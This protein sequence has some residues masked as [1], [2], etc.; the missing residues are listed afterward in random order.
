MS[1]DLKGSMV[2]PPLLMERPGGGALTT[3]AL[4]RTDQDEAWDCPSCRCFPPPPTPAPPCTLTCVP[5]GGADGG[6]RRTPHSPSGS[7]CGPGPPPPAQ[8]GRSP[9]TGRNTR[10]EERR[11]GQDLCG[12]HSPKQWGTPP[13]LTP[14]LFLPGSSGHTCLSW[15]LAW[16]FPLTPAHTGLLSVHESVHPANVY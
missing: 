3:S 1:A 4:S 6:Y 5:P 9:A 12:K 8:R 11:L 13:S 10:G 15:L 7:T 16:S 14:I 2:V